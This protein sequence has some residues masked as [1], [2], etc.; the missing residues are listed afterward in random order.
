MANSVWGVMHQ[1][2]GVS[3]WWPSNW[4]GTGSSLSLYRD[5]EDGAWSWPLIS[6]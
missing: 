3:M 4:M 5:E 6:I 2:S 1:Y